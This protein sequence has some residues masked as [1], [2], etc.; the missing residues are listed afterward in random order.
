MEQKVCMFLLQNCDYPRNK[1]LFEVPEEISE[2]VSVG[3]LTE[4]IENKPVTNIAV[5]KHTFAGVEV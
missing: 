3:V 4:L 5:A 2:E 1:T